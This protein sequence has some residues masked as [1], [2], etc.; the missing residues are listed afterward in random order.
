MPLYVWEILIILALI[1]AN[2]FFSAAEL[3]VIASRRGR[4][5][6]LA[7]EGDKRA[8]QALELANDPARFLPTVQVGI[9]LVG[10]FTATFGGAS[11]VHELAD[12]L[13]AVP[14]S[15][16]AQH[17]ARRGAGD[18]GAGDYAGDAPAGRT[19][20]Q[21]NCAAPLPSN[22]LASSRRS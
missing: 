14:W 16:I 5:R 1:L 21:A 13:V 6:Q 8:R 17:C 3:A 10:T 12:F 9:T 22:W 11:L 19:G 20:S 4:L 18:R 7:E 15:P 2:G